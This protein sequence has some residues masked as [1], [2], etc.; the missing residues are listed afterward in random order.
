MA[1]ETVELV[2]QLAHRSLD[3]SDKQHLLRDLVGL[4][5]EAAALALN[6]GKTAYTAIRLIELGRNAIV[7]S[8]KGMRVDVTDLEA[9][10]PGL[11]KQYI[12]LRDELHADSSEERELETLS[13]EAEVRYD[14]SQ[15]FDQLLEA[16]RLQPGFETFLLT[17]SEEEMRRAAV[18]GTI[19][20]LNPCYD[21]ID[22]LVIQE[23]RIFNIPLP[24]LDLGDI[25]DWEVDVSRPKSLDTKLLEWMWDVLAGPVLEELGFLGPPA[26]GQPWSRI[27]WVPTGPLTKFP[28]HAAGYHYRD[29]FETVL[30]RVVSSYSSSVGS[31]VMSRRGL[32]RERTRRAGKAVLVGM[33]EPRYAV[34]EISHIEN[35]F[36]A[37]GIAE[38]HKPSPCRA[39]VMEALKDCEIFHF[40]GH[41]RSDLD[42]SQSGLLLRDG[43]LTLA[44]LLDVH[45][46][47]RQLFLAYLSA[48][49]SGQMKSDSLVE[50]S[51]HLSAAFQLAG[52]RHAIGTMWEASDRS[53][54]DAAVFTY[55]WMQRH[56]M[57]DESVSEGLHHAIRELRKRWLRRGGAGGMSGHR[58]DVEEGGR[59]MREGRTVVSWEDAP[60]D[61]VPFVHYGV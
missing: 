44:S 33:S 51:L 28:I 15:E 8:L 19:V 41:G 34:Q 25:E 38:V 30:D 56:G 9:H 55:G 3:N 46:E 22:A 4:G 5:T 16:I 58:E 35:L 37:E 20:V 11:A 48:C 52:F 43:R 1:E 14:A 49:G 57:S 40:A 26:E 6:I 47:S 32:V 50:E 23:S 29:T 60:L 54:V 45:I 59:D 31:I 61:W 42:P 36:K 10:H 18:G 7:G 13:R 12:I 27:W 2:P 39:D 17:P 21:R 24:L 53:C